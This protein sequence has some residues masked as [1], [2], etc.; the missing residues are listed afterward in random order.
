MDLDQ[1]GSTIQRIQTAH[2]LNLANIWG[3]R[4]GDRILEIGCGQGD[5]TAVLAYLTGESGAVYGIDIASPDYGAPLTL[6]EAAAKLLQS[7]LG[8]R[9]QIQFETD[10]LSSDIE[11]EANHFDVIVLSHCSWYLESADQL[12]AMIRKA[13]R[14]GKRLCFA[15]WDVRIQMPEQYPHLLAVLIQAQYEVYQL[16]SSSNVRTMFTVDQ[17]RRIAESAGWV[18]SREEVLHSPDLQDGHWEIDMALHAYEE[19]RQGLGHGP[20]KLLTLMQSE[21]YMLQQA[22]CQHGVKPLSTFIL[23]AE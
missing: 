16:D 5:T 20:S 21:L 11:Y 18:V 15:E 19:A 8:S 4:E 14:W 12:E 1:S 2:R 22:K 7:P 10:I 6:G 3:I 17:V 13:R 9:I 23:N